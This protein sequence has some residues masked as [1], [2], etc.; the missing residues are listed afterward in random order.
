[1]FEFT[2]HANELGLLAGRTEHSWDVWIQGPEKHVDTKYEIVFEATNNNQ[3][4]R[5]NFRKDANLSKNQKTQYRFDNTLRRAFGIPESLE[6]IGANV[7]ISLIPEY[8][9]VLLTVRTM[10]WK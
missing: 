5:L 2:K 6:F 4:D 1:M 7:L 9:R 10:Q 8:R 3:H